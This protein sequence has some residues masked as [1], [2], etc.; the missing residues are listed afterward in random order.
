M[1]HWKGIVIILFQKAGVI[2]QHLSDTG[3]FFEM[4]IKQKK[5]KKIEIRRSQLN[6]AGYI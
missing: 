1:A 6:L 5:T 3:K 2:A 4:C